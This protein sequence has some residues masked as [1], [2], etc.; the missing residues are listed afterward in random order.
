MVADGSFE[1]IDRDNPQVFA[2][3]RDLDDAHLLVV[4]NFEKQEAPFAIPQEFDGGEVLVS[5][6]DAPAKGMLRPFEAFMILKKA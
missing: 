2:Y 5:N 6:Y 1:L 3:R 4:C